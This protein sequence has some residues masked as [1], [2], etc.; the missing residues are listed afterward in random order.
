MPKG[1]RAAAREESG[2]TLVELLVVVVVIAI[3]AA[4]A[5]PSFL[6]RRIGAG[7][8][9][10]KEMVRT[11]QQTAVNYGLANGYAGMT[12]SALKTLERTINVN[13]N[14]Q[15]VLVNANPTLSGYLLTVVASTADTFNLTSTNGVISR[16]CIV[17]AGNGNTT[18]NTGGG[19]TNGVW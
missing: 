11:A 19:C 4:I 14:G 1:V 9:G 2:F 3:L 17:A 16:T 7:D 8:A 5:I 18:T 15:A 12:P 6:G 13:A 10:A